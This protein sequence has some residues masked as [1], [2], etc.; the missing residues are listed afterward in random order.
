MRSLYGQGFEF[1]NIAASG[2]AGGDGAGG[3]FDYRMSAEG[4]GDAARP[5]I[6]ANLYD[7][8]IAIKINEVE[9]DLHSEGMY[10]FAGDDPEPFAWLQIA[11]A[12]E[13]FIAAGSGIGDLDRTAD[14]SLTSAVA[15][16]QEPGW[17]RFLRGKE[18]P[19]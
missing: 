10:G 4:S 15:N 3:K 11:A 6:S 19:P 17:A 1:E 18:T 2:L 12:E 16:A 7:A 9:R 8:P 13:P 14:F 5:D